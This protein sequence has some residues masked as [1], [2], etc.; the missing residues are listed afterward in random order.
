MFESLFDHTNAIWVIYTVGL[1]SSGLQSVVNNARGG[2]SAKGE[3]RTV[4][5]WDEAQT[6]LLRFVVDLSYNKLHKRSTVKIVQ[7]QNKILTLSHLRLAIK[8][9]A[10]KITYVISCYFILQWRPNSEQAEIVEIVTSG[11]FIDAYCE[12]PCLF[13]FYQFLSICS[14][15]TQQ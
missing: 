12:K 14:I 5:A 1:K 10:N 6:P 7:Q 8:S 2:L 11:A 9:H 13:K 3:S 4:F 15:C